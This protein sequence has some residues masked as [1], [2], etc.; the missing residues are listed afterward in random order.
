MTFL[1]SDESLIRLESPD[2]ATNGTVGSGQP[3][4][5]IE[6]AQFL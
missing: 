3:G 4:F 2:R 1:K 6:L 5:K